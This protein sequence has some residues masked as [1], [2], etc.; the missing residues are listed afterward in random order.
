MRRTLAPSSKDWLKDFFSGSVA[1][2]ARNY[3]D[4]NGRTYLISRWRFALEMVEATVVPGAKVLDVGCGTGAMG[5]GLMRRGYEVWGVDLAEAMIR[6]VQ[7]RLGRGRFGVGDI[8]HIPFRDNTFD[9]VVCLGVVE[10]LEKDEPAL[11]EVRRVLRPGGIAVISTPSALRPFYHIDRVLAGVTTPVRPL[12]RFVKYRL[13]GGPAP[14]PLTS[15]PRLHHRRYYRARWLRLLGSVGL[16][17]EA[18]ICHSWEC[19]TVGRFWGHASLCRIGDKFA[20]NPALNWL[21]S[22]QLV[23]VR[24]VK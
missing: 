17:P 12:Y 22:H 6:Y 2:W 1:D 24:A 21:G 16:E 15:R 3:A 4:L 13:R 19:D 7:E 8:E 5:G 23:Q 11:R 18:W 9:A 10:Y 14:H 20:R